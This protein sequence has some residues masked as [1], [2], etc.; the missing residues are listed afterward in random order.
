MSWVQRGLLKTNKHEHLWFLVSLCG[1]LI[2][3]FRINKLG[4]TPGMNESAGQVHV[5]V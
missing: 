5:Y 4:R 3:K 1:H 2:E